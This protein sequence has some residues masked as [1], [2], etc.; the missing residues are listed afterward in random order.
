VFP[1]I[2]AQPVIPLPF[3][4]INFMRQMINTARAHHHLNLLRKLVAEF[5]IPT[6]GPLREVN[7]NLLKARHQLGIGFG[8]HLGTS[9][10]SGTL[11]SAFMRIMTNDKRMPEAADHHAPVEHS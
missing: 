10:Q 8:H 9:A 5:K 11:Y 1:G 7:Q 2:E 3:R 6:D 4:M